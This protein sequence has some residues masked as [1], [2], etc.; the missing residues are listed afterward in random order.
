M[1]ATNGHGPHRAILHASVSTD[2][3]ARTGFSFH[4]LIKNLRV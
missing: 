3:Q 1:P 2:E 4:Q